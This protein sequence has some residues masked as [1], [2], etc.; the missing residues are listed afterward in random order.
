MRFLRAPIAGC[1]HPS[2]RSRAG[3]CLKAAR[4][5]GRFLWREAGPVASR[6]LHSSRNA[7]AA[8]ALFVFVFRHRLHERDEP[9]A[10]L[11]IGDAHKGARQLHAFRCRQEISHITGRNVAAT[12]PWLL[13]R[14]T[15]SKKNSIGTPSTLAI[16]CKRLAPMR[17][18]PFSYFAL[19]ESIPALRQVFPGSFGRSTVA[20]GRGHQRDD[21]SDWDFRHPRWRARVLG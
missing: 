11:G 9:A 6:K 1:P 15:P 20:C 3:E 12:T 2:V 17:L 21:L 10:D 13:T 8:R 7:T 18:V 4:P 14:G 19:L 16:C 5:R